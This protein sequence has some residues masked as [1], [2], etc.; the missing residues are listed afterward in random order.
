MI[1]RILLAMRLKKMGYELMT[2]DEAGA[3]CA[4]DEEICDFEAW[5]VIFNKYIVVAECHAIYDMTSKRILQIWS[6]DIA[7][8]REFAK[9]DR[10]YLNI[11]MKYDKRDRNEFI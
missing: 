2:K 8:M 3:M 9:V 6:R 4:S 5:R 11:L 10:K 7:A 1:K